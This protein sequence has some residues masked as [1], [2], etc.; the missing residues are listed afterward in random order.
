MSEIINDGSQTVIKPGT[1]L[2][3]AMADSFKGELLT[4]ISGSQGGIAIDLQG[5]EQVDAI[6]VGVIIAAYNS[7]NQKGRELKLINAAKDV[8]ALFSTM[9]LDRRI[10][11]AAA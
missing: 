2:V 7:L 4:V 10:T 3:A 11:V 8:F 5:V 9:R 1:D 6:G